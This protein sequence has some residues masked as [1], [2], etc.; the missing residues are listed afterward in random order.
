MIRIE[1]YWNYFVLLVIG[2][3]MVLNYGFMQLR[4]PPMVGGG[5]PVG[6]LL[7]LGCLLTID[8][9]KLIPRMNKS[10]FILPLLL[11]WGYGLTR[12]GIGYFQHGFWALRDATSVIESL[13]LIVGFT[14][15]SQ[16]HRYENLFKWLPKL[17]FVVVLYGLSFPFREMLAPLSPQITGGAGGVV[18]V[19]FTYTNTATM[20]LFT[21]VY[22]LLFSRFSGDTGIRN[23]II[24]ALLL[25]FTLI[26]F[27]ARIIYLEW[28][29][30]AVFLALFRQKILG[31]VGLALVLFFLVLVI[32]PVL[33]LEIK[34]RLGQ[35][36]N[37]QFFLSHFMTI[38]GISSSGL[39]GSASGV[40][41]R[42]EWW[43]TLYDTWISSW[44]NMFFGLG[45]GN[46]LIDFMVSSTVAVREPHN[47][48][49][50]ILARQGIIGL[51]LF[52]W[53]HLYL[54][55]SWF[56]TYLCCHRI[57]W[58]QGENRLLLLMSFFIMMWITSLAEDGF[59]KPFMAIP[60]YF[61]WGVILR[62]HWHLLMGRLPVEE[63]S[64]KDSAQDTMLHAH[65]AHS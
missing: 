65:P 12:A 34:G 29:V 30:V 39:E 58:R 1:S 44:K 7:L 8:Y 4:F 49:V 52:L 37:L 38:L 57:G 45:F 17:L 62:M 59:E 16:V 55:R 47:S 51:C 61:F 15:A 63:H 20:L 24:I 11:W 48:F 53:L 21:V 22:L 9:R 5:I 36:A 14:Y 13:F 46:P 41:Q 43:L 54:V 35:I 32:L 60:F 27:Q 10:V 28:I 31:R 18:P 25:S 23:I 19:F 50:S 6:E 42:L 2:L 64:P 3:Y 56:R 26:F 40:H 33:G